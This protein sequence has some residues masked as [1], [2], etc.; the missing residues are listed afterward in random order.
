MD[1]EIV[2]RINALLKRGSGHM[3]HKGKNKSSKVAKADTK[4]DTPKER[5]GLLYLL[6]KVWKYINNYPVI[7]ELAGIAIVAL[8]AY[9]SGFLSLPK[10]VSDLEQSTNNLVE[11]IE[12]I[13][14]M[15][16]EGNF[17]SMKDKLEDLDDRMDRVEESIMLSN[18]LK[19]EPTAKAIDSIHVEYV[20]TGSFYCLSAPTWNNADI[21]AKDKETGKEYNVSEL[22]NKK[23]LLP[24]ENNGQ[25]ILFYGQFN[26]NNQWNGE[27]IINIYENNNLILITEANYED[28]KIL[29]YR[30][31]IPFTT[32]RGVD[33][34]CVSER[35]S[36]GDSNSGDSWT[37]LRECEYVKNF[38]LS[39]ANIDNICNV[40]EFVDN[41]DT[42]LEGFYHGNTSN[43]QFNDETGEAY[44]IK[45]SEDGSIKT[46][47]EG[48]FKDGDF[49]DNTGD[50]WYITKEKNT[51]YMYYKGVFKNGKPTND[52]NS[53]FENPITLERI[54]QILQENDFN[55]ELKWYNDYIL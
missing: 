51:G 28:G 27:C 37:Y 31:V 12:A 4:K 39:L 32:K 9:V 25:E 10:N 2:I 44:M 22:A 7:T 20:E 45:Y 23:M 40:D 16:I 42:K 6:K 24:Y 3:E 26:N 50:A 13:E 17:Q 11:R 8:L 14:N 41:I 49:N 53:I 52:N 54:E 34:W 33:V 36:N 15:D 46:L 47:Y 1:G 18:L 48:R 30:Q 38:E 43:G 19:L 5:I 55:G 21:I 35:K 29:N